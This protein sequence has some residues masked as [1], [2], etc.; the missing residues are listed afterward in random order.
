MHDKE[1]A[2]GLPYASNRLLNRGQRISEILF[3]R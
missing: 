3:G 2:V 1:K